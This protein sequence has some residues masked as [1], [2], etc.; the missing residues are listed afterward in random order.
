MLESLI[1]EIVYENRN[2]NTSR[3]TKLKEGNYRSASSTDKAKCE[4]SETK[5][6]SHT[7]KQ[8]FPQPQTESAWYIREI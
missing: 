5:I 8:C 3:G 6:T 1:K 2:K 7:L 4:L